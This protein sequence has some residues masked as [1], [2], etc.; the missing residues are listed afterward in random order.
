ML[1]IS[2]IGAGDIKFHYFELLQ[3]PEEK[4][5][6]QVTEI[7]KVLADSEVELVLLPDRGICFEVAKK[8]KEYFGK[9]VYGTVPY[10]DRDFGIKHLQQFIDAKVNG[11]K[12]IDETID[13]QNWYKQDLTHCLF[14]DIVLMLG[15]SLGSL[16]E[17]VYGYYLH[18]LFIGNK[19]EVNIAKQKIHPEIKAG[20]KIPFSVI[21]YKPFV[22]EKLNF[23][24][25]AYIKKLSGEIHYVNDSQE[26]KS[27]LDKLI[28]SV[29]S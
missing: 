1:K 10:S 19:S 24:I 17:L 13:T 20:E 26:L 16:G 15:N 4:F 9:K 23:E 25:E 21:V 5:N 22:K 7:A 14:G 2:L 3:I 28:S 8:Y 11:A 18:K 29:N 6:K 27:V 12:I